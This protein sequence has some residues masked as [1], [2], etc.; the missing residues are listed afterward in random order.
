M[1]ENVTNISHEYNGNVTAYSYTNNRKEDK[2][3]RRLM[4]LVKKCKT[5][6]QFEEQVLKWLHYYEVPPTWTKV[7]L[8]QFYNQHK[9]A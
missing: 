6:R 3:M 7:H 2:T 1:I 5:Y 8:E 4:K 9:Q